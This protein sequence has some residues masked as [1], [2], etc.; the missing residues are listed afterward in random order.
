MMTYEHALAQH[1]VPRFPHLEQTELRECDAVALACFE[2]LGK[3]Y[4]STR[5][6][7]RDTIDCSTLV[8]QSHWIG[9]AIQIPFIAET[10]RLARTATVVERSDMLPGDSIYAYA[11]KQDSPGGRHN[12]VVLFIG[13]DEYGTPWAMDA[14]EECGVILRDLRLV[15]SAGGIRRFCIEPLEVFSGGPWSL[16]ARRVPKLG[17]FGARLTVDS[18]SGRRHAGIDIYAP[19]GC[20]VLSPHTGSVVEAFVT[21]SGA[22][23]IGIWSSSDRMYSMVGP[24]SVNSGICVGRDVSRGD[25]LGRLIGGASLGRCNAIP[26]HDRRERLH[27]ELW[28]TRSFG[29][30]PVPSLICRDLPPLVGTEEE[31]V[32]QNALY[33]VK[34]GNVGPCLLGVSG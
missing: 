4:R 10:Q 31:L 17:R 32:A 30:P 5:E 9:A 26:E 28:T 14:R 13:H 22:S 6:L 16:M 33:Y 3:S 11:K 29:V 24:I 8:S 2:H 25:A 21:T 23:M 19:T 34:R 12:H 1:I 7:Q 18:K 27:W 15:K 20:D